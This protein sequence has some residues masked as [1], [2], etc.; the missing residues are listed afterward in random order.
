MTQHTTQSNPHCAISYPFESLCVW[1]KWGEL[2]N[3][4]VMNSLPNTYSKSFNVI[5]DCWRWRM[6]FS[7]E[8]QKS[9]KQVKCML[10][11]MINWFPTYSTY[12]HKFEIHISHSEEEKK[13]FECIK[14]HI[15]MAWYL[16]HNKPVD[17]NF[18]LSFIFIVV[19]PLQF[20]LHIPYTLYEMWLNE[21]VATN[22][23]DEKKVFH[24]PFSLF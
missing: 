4:P 1:W 22:E 19:F 10:L 12:L 11:L 24:V 6:M 20:I 5:F 23:R 16:V 18:V 3:K 14:Q 9:A 13:S 7:N 2:Y 15:W 8:T 21:M 17:G